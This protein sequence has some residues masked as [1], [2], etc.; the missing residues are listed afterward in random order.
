MLGLH[1]FVRVLSSCGK[2]GLPLVWVL[3]LLIAVASLFA[4]HGLQGMWASVAAARELSSCD[5]WTLELR[6]KIVVLGLSSMWGLPRPEI[7]LMSPALA[8]EFLSTVPPGKSLHDILTEKSRLKHTWVFSRLKN[9]SCQFKKWKVCLYPLA[10]YALPVATA[11][12][13]RSSVLPVAQDK[14]SV[15]FFYCHSQSKLTRCPLTLYYF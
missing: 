12:A 11:T 7:K 8:G 3:G 15:S 10:E 14:T 13:N 5:S 9:Q 2:W 6:L 4:K 1:C